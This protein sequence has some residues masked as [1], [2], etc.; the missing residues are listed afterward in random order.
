MQL[1]FFT[2]VGLPMFKA[3]ADVF[4]GARPMLENVMGNYRMWEAAAADV[5]PAP[6]PM[7][8]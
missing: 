3:V 2:I 6:S 1:G 4:E 7:P 8:S 5:A